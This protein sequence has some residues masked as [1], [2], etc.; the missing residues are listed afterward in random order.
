[1]RWLAYGHPALMLVALALAALA[2][3]RG[4]ALRRQRLLGVRGRGTALASHLAIARPAVALLVVGLMGGLASTV[5]LRDWQPLGTLHGWAGVVA[6]L[7]FAA[8]GRLG[9]QLQHGRSQAVEL[10]A[11]LALLAVLAGAVTAVAGFVLLP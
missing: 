8:T 3:R 10:H 6:V 1:M 5:W 2:L 4:L 11:R 7:L 9:W